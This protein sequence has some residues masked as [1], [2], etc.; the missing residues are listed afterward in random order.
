MVIDSES[1]FDDS[2]GDAD[3]NDVSASVHE[4]RAL[5]Y[6]NTSG[7]EALQE[8]T[9]KHPYPLIFDVISQIHVLGCSPEQASA[10][11]DL[12]PFDSPD[13]ARSKLAQGKKKSN[14]LT[15]R[16]FEDCVRMLQGY[17]TV[18]NVLEECERIGSKLRKAIAS[19]SL[20]EKEKLITEN[21]DDG[22][23]SLVSLHTKNQTPQNYLTTQPALLAPGVTLKE[24]QLLG[25]NWLNLL[26]SSNYSC[27]LADEMGV[28]DSRFSVSTRLML[29]RS[30]KNHSGDKLSG[31]SQTTGKDGPSSD[32]CTVSTSLGCPSFVAHQIIQF[33]DVGKLVSRVR[34]ICA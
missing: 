20:E 9:G 2:D 5:E 13:A 34:E 23:L 8:L 21:D 27:I 14:G 10:I 22:G 17:G 29:P 6:L 18:D 25:V 7:A 26:Y 1:D 30:W 24:Y 33:V 32:C 19:W 12:R 3:V 28:Q 4:I 16:M 11:I 31:L 15:A